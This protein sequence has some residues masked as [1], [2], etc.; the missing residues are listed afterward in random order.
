MTLTIDK[1]AFVGGYNQTYWSAGSNLVN[2]DANKTFQVNPALTSDANYGIKKYY[3]CRII[4][5]MLKGYNSTVM[6]AQL[7]ATNF[8][9]TFLPNNF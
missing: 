8:T 7:V 1:M 4:A 5:D 9:G 2:T 6:F 3:D